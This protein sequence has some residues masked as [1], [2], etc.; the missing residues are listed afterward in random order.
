MAYYPDYRKI[1]GTSNSA[2][3]LSQILYY[4]KN[5]EKAG[6][7][8]FYKTDSEFA[9]ALGFSIKEFRTAKKALT[10]SGIVIVI[11]RGVPSTSYYSVDMDLF[12]KGLKSL[13][14]GDRTLGPLGTNLPAAEGQTNSETTTETTREYTE[15]TA[16]PVKPVQEWDADRC[17]PEILGKTAL[18]RLVNVYV[19]GFQDVY[20]FKPYLQSWAMIGRVYKDIMGTYTEWQIASLIL[21]QFEWRGTHGDDEF[22]YKQLSNRSFPLEWVPRSASSY[23]AYIQNSLG[24]DFENPAQIRKWVSDIIIPIMKEYGNPNAKDNVAP[25]TA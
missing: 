15:T 8:E 9:E 22:S 7:K 21:M 11:K 6:Q 4:Q 1:T 12:Q 3:L 19:L 13:T 24:V 5:K 20:G 18:A 14:L 16:V 10:E 2:I 23:R 25:I 17:L